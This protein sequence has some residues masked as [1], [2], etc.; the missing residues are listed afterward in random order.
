MIQ[1]GVDKPQRLLSSVDAFLVD[2]VDNSSN[3]GAGHG[4]TAVEAHGAIASKHAIVAD[5]GNV[6]VTSATSIVDTSRRNLAICSIVR[7]VGRLVLGEVA[8]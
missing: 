6:R 2:A 8:V 3:N 1:G 7:L 5:G 4:G